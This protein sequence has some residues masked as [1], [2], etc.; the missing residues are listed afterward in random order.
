MTHNERL[1]FM[2]QW[3]KDLNDIYPDENK[4]EIECLSWAIKECHKNVSRQ[5]SK[6]HSIGKRKENYMLRLSQAR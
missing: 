1:K 6:K 3:L 2:R 5:E 4:K